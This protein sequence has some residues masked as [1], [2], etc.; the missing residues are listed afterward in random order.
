MWWRTFNG[1]VGGAGQAEIASPGGW[2]LLVL[3]EKNSESYVRCIGKMVVW[4]ND[5]RTKL[6]H[7]SI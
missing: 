3:L 1:N 4:Y 2:V 7:S 6:L 5:S